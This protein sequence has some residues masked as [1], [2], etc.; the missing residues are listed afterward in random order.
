MALFE[1]LE[2]DLNQAL[3]T[4]NA[5][6]LGVLRLVMAALKNR[7]IE[8]RVK[9]QILDDSEVL[10]ILQREIKRRKEAVEMF[11]KGGRQDLADKDLAEIKVLEKYLPEQMSEE[12]IKNMAMDVKEQMGATGAGDFGKVMK[13]VM[14]KVG[15]KSDGNVVSKIVRE[16]LG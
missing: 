13:E 4:Q 9:K 11:L 1:T 2:A 14:I 6:V 16:I 5:E 12:E 8:L 15:G 3:K 10:A 7:E